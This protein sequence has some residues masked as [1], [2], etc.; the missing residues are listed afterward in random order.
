MRAGKRGKDGRE[1]FLGHLVRGQPA[2]ALS[3][4]NVRLYGVKILAVGRLA[5]QRQPLSNFNSARCLSLNSAAVLPATA[6]GLSTEYWSLR[7]KPIPFPI[8][9]MMFAFR[10]YG[11]TITGQYCAASAGTSA[12]NTATG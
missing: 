8:R 5:R 2:S 10:S 11:R 1:N 6:L 3:R 4:K 12:A 7:L 9:F